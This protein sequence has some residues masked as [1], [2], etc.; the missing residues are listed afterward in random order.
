MKLHV[1]N[2]KICSHVLMLYG[3]RNVQIRLL[4]W[5][6]LQTLRAPIVVQQFLKLFCQHHPQPAQ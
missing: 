1:Y 5:L 3:K 4:I 6:A 2:V